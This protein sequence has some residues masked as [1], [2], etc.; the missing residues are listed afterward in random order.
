[1]AN[2]LLTGGAGFIA[3]HT[4]LILLRAG[5]SVVILDNFSNSSPLVIG[6]L[7]ELSDFS[8]HNRLKLVNGDVRIGASLD[9]AF[10]AFSDD[11]AIDAVI[12]F[13]GVK[14]VAES[15][16]DPLK[17]WNI[18][19]A[20][21]SRLLCAMRSFAC[22]TI[23]FSSS[24]TVYGIPEVNPITELS[25]IKPINP[26]GRSKAAVERIL[27]DVVESEPGWR[28]A[29]LRYFNPVGAHPSGRLGEDSSEVPTN[30]FPIIGQVAVG[31]RTHLDIYGRDWPTPDGSCIRDYIHVLDLA[32][33]H[34]AALDHLLQGDPQF[35]TL[36][37][38][39]GRGYSVI[40]VVKAYEAASGKPIPFAVKPR[41][42]GDV[43]ITV[44]DP[45]MAEEL[46]N[47]RCHRSL[48][49]MCLDSWCWHRSNPRGYESSS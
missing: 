17:Y 48:V 26:Y 45:R 20:G 43:G 8:V 18:N 16:T 28:V 13:A 49:D 41:R 22:K 42:A 27:Q 25:A 33:G 47:W 38:G 19:L 5:H 40:E 9:H 37:L 36:N 3:S 10:R 4:A 24:C 31:E 32:E 21:S 15:V 1:M 11:Q 6:R 44:A 2:L 34:R 39:S 12:H 14:S 46:L 30:L 23:V 29:C 35:L 7:T